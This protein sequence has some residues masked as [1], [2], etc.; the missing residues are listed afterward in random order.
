ML[1]LIDQRDAAEE[2]VSNI[3]FKVTGR[4]PEWSNNF[5]FAE[6]LSDIEDAVNLLKA[7]S[8][9]ALSP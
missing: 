4:S 3:Y 8:K 9:A 7:A 5:G 2:C 6:A 1:Q